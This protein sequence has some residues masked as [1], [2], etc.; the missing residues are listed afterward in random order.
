MNLDVVFRTIYCH[1]RDSA[2]SF[3]LKNRYMAEG[4]YF[5]EDTIPHLKMRKKL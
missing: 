3:Y 2:V 1:A 4:D 5:D